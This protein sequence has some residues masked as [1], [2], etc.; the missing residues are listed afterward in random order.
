MGGRKKRPLANGPVTGA[1]AVEGAL[2]WADAEDSHND[3]AVAAALPPPTT[4]RTQ[5]SSAPSVASQPRGGRKPAT[6]SLADFLSGGSR[7][8]AGGGAPKRGIANRAADV[9]PAASDHKPSPPHVP[10]AET[11]SEATLPP[12]RSSATKAPTSA[13]SEAPR[14]FFTGRTTYDAVPAQSMDGYNGGWCAPMLPLPRSLLD[15]LGVPSGGDAGGNVS[16]PPPVQRQQSSLSSRGD[17]LRWLKDEMPYPLPQWTVEENPSHLLYQIR[18][19]TLRYILIDDRY[20]TNAFRTQDVIFMASALRNNASV[21]SIVLRRLAVREIAIVTL[22]HSLRSHTHV[23][24]LDFLGTELTVAGGEA[25]RDLLLANTGIVH[26][27]GIF[28]DEEVTRA[29]SKIERDG[30]PD[31]AFEGHASSGAFC[32]WLPASLVHEIRMLAQYNC[33]AQPNVWLDDITRWHVAEFVAGLLTAAPTD[34]SPRP[35]PGVENDDSSPKNPLPDTDLE[36]ATAVQLQAAHIQAKQEDIIRTTKARVSHYVC[37]HPDDESYEHFSGAG[38]L[39]ADGSSE[40]LGSRMQ[41][42]V[43]D[44]RLLLRH[45]KAFLISVLSR[46]VCSNAVEPEVSVDKL[47]A[48]ALGGLVGWATT[49]R[50]RDALTLQLAAEATLGCPFGCMCRLFHAPRVA[51]NVAAGSA[52]PV[53]P[54]T[55][56]KQAVAVT[57]VPPVAAPLP[58]ADP[59]PSVTVEPTAEG[60]LPGDVAAGDATAKKKRKKKKKKKKKDA[61][62]PTTI[63]PAATGERTGG[64]DPED[65]D[66]AGDDDTAAADAAASLPAVTQTATVAPG[67]EA[68]P[69]SLDDT[70]AGPKKKKKKKKKK[71]GKDIIHPST[72]TRDG[73]TMAPGEGLA[74][75]GG[76][77]D[78]AVAIDYG[79][80]YLAQL[81]AVVGDGGRQIETNLAAGHWKGALA[82]CVD[83]IPRDSVPRQPAPAPLPRPVPLDNHAG[84]SPC[85]VMLGA[86]TVACVV[87]GVVGSL[88]A[89][90]VAQRVTGRV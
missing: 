50:Q 57:T 56:V 83:G 23:R 88:L 21:V 86:G 36:T 55:G 47:D 67:G 30:S 59:P 82:E 25:I 75:G 45:F 11:K 89:C 64:G 35:A 72:S 43:D 85:M 42:I 73:S 7:P 77:M 44:D 90:M 15:E 24:S 18:R 76:A 14:V 70:A 20:G 22:C 53:K 39:V 32:S 61:D 3:G 37:M 29:A 38:M 51:I 60:G 1:G 33:L 12:R 9:D 27:G 87:T 28:T 17:E 63:D 5:P 13:P 66:D 6:V 34:D 52:A 10:V 49:K 71:K 46:P 54:T 41:G 58:R 78:P 74:R 31:D 65:D 80:G 26:V 40:R 84:G 19:H 48:H 16:F 62:A 4:T 81:F 79:E 69:I 68:A 8:S 2:S